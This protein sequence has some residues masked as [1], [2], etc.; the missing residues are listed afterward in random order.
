M[1]RSRP[2]STRPSC[3]RSVVRLPSSMEGNYSGQLG[4]VDSCGRTEHPVGTRTS[5][6]SR[7]YLFPISQGSRKGS[8]SQSGNC[9]LA[10]EGCSRGASTAQVPS[11]LL[12]THLSGEE[13]VRSLAP[14]YRP[15]CLQSVRGLSSLSDGDPKRYHRLSEGRNVG[16]FNRFEGCLLPHSH[17]EVGQEVSSLFPRGQDISV[18][19]YA[20]WPYHSPHGFY[21]TSA[22]CGRF[23]APAKYQHPYLLRRLSHASFAEGVPG[24]GYSTGSEPF[25]QGRVYPFQREVRTVSIPGLC[26]PRL[27]VPCSQG[28]SPPNSGEIH[29]GQGS[30]AS[31]YPEFCYTGSLVPQSAGVSQLTSRCGSSGQTT[32]Q[33]AADVPSQPVG[34]CIKGLGGFHSSHPVCQGICPVVDSSEQCPEGGVLAQELT[35]H[36]FVYRRVQDRLGGVPER[37]F[38]F[39]SVDRGS[40][41]RAHQCA[42]DEGS[43]VSHS[44][45]QVLPARPGNLCGNGQLH[46]CSLSAKAR[47]HQVSC[48]VRPGNSHLATLPGIVSNHPGQAPSRQTQCPR[49]HPVETSS[50]GSDGVATQSIHFPCNLSGLGQAS[51]R[52]ICHSLKP[53]VADVCVSRPRSSSM[54]SRCS[55]SGLDG[56]T[57]LRVSPLQPG[58]QGPPEVRGAALLPNSSGSLVAETTMVSS[59]SVVSGGRTFGSPTQVEPVATAEVQNHA[60]PPSYT[61][62]SRVEAISGG[63]AQE[64]FSGPVSDCIARSI[65][66]SSATVY[67]SRWSIF[68]NWCGQRQVDPLKA[69][70]PLIADFL[71]HLFRSKNLAPGTIAGYRSAIAGILSYAGRSEVG[72]SS[73]LSALIRGF[74]IERPRV[75]RLTPQW[76]LALVLE[77][78]LGAP[79][80]PLSQASL[81]FLTFKTVFLITLASGRRRSEVHALSGHS[82]C[83][84]FGRNYSSVT[85]RT[86]P[87]FLAKNQVP[88]FSPEPIRIPS[89][90]D[91]VGKDER[92]RLLCPVRA[93]RYYLD[94]TGSDRDVQS[95]LFLPIKSGQTSISAQSISRW[96]C[97]VIKLAYESSSDEVRR[98]FKVRAHEVRALAASWALLN[99]SPFSEVMSSAFWRGHTT[100]TEFYLRS[101]SSFSDKLY[102]LGPVVVAQSVARPP[103]SK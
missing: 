94:R 38:S 80:E 18:P 23:P 75:R 9:Y 53:S 77:S 54:G 50:A 28:H 31:V 56:V 99:G 51:C 3:R 62:P 90:S 4:I 44:G 63:L 46:C 37:A 72:S 61:P 7:A 73:S 58:G 32:H 84:R 89:L 97:Q 92:D 48:P 98:L 68:C 25:H 76:D 86:E 65:R 79:Y 85:I 15:E 60:L 70:V 11:R 55:V 103:T 30:G 12:F 27:P 102:S 49:R 20:F 101:L 8:G 1:G 39:R 96:I 88:G 19:G 22:G 47:G 66:A 16:Y 45:P 34:S 74:S 78:L 42:R 10:Q 13:K 71:L 21:Q 59:A 64:G 67:Q 83:L 33:T 81:K 6:D 17:Q 91:L 36:D 69:S 82:S 29:Q 24:A 87:S 2:P 40:A 52:P 95:R 41:H 5:T 14:D 100:F 43:V 26:F 57:R 93:L 35:H